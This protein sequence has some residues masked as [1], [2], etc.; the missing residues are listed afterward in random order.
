MDAEDTKKQ[1][2]I[3]ELQAVVAKGL[4]G[5]NECRYQTECEFARTCPGTC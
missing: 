1:N 3:R 4:K 2:K 5:I